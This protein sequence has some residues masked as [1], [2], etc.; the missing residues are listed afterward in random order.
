[1]PPLSL[2]KRYDGHR[3]RGPSLKQFP[4]RSDE[5]PPLEMLLIQ[6]EPK[7]KGAR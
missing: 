4:T 3:F 5:S 6:K 2:T 1:M 7:K